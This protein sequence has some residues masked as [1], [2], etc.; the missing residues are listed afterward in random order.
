MISRNE[1]ITAVEL[2]SEAIV[3]IA[4]MVRGERI[5]EEILFEYHSIVEFISPYEGLAVTKMITDTYKLN[6]QNFVNSD[7]IKMPIKYLACHILLNAD[8]A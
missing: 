7:V 4:E 3:K 8:I 1:L 5:N 2:L 6:D